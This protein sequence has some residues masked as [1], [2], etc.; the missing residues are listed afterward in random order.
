MASKR[1]LRRRQSHHPLAA[2]TD[3][4]IVATGRPTARN[5]RKFH[6]ARAAASK[7]IDA[8]LFTGNLGWVA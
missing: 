6:T 4:L 5:R 7:H 2:L 8:A 3:A 1:Q